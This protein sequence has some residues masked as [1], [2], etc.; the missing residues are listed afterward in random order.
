MDRVESLTS[1]P[2]PVRWTAALGAS[3]LDMKPATRL[4]AGWLE[5]DERARV[6]R[7]A[8]KSVPKTPEDEIK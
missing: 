4:S 3:F 8:T 6:P 7:R 5:T 2:T 1:T